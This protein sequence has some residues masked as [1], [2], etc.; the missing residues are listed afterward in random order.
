MPGA[1]DRSRGPDGEHLRVSR[2]VLV[3]NGA[4][5]SASDRLAITHD[6]KY[7]DFA[8]RIIKL[9]YGKVISQSDPEPLSGVSAIVAGVH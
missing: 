6:D 8:D 1:E 9:D 7:F 4:I 3:A 5:A 2:W